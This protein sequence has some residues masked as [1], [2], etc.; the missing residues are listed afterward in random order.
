MS[1]IKVPNVGW[2]TLNVL[3]V[4]HNRYSPRKVAKVANSL[5]E[6][7][8]MPLFD[9]IEGD[10]T[11]FF[12]SQGT[13]FDA[14]VKSFMDRMAL[15]ESR[16]ELLR[17]D[18][19]NNFHSVHER[20]DRSRATVADAAV[21]AAA[22]AASSSVLPVVTV[23]DGRNEELE[24]YTMTLSRQLNMVLELL[25]QPHANDAVAV[26]HA[27][28]AQFHSISDVLTENE[29]IL[30]QLAMHPEPRFEAEQVAVPVEQIHPAV[31][32]DSSM[33]E[34]LNGSSLEPSKP[35]PDPI[36]SSLSLS[37]AQEQP[38]VVVPNAEAAPPALQ[39]AQTEAKVAAVA[40]EKQPD[41][42]T[43]APKQE[44][45]T[46]S[47]IA[48]ATAINAKEV[49][50]NEISDNQTG[51]RK[52]E[53][54]DEDDEEALDVMPVEARFQSPPAHSEDALHRT[55]SF[56]RSCQDLQKS[57][58]V[59]L[60][61][62]RLREEE[63]MRRLQQLLLQS[64]A[65]VQHEHLAAWQKQQ[66][67]LHGQHRQQQT[68][69]MQLLR[70]LEIQL[71]DQQQ[72]E[73]QHFQA[74]QV[75][76]DQ[77]QRAAD[78]ESVQREV[79]HKLEAINTL[80]A[81][82]QATH[83][84]ELAQMTQLIGDL[85]TRFVSSDTLEAAAAVWLQTAAD[86]CVYGASPATLAKLEQDMEDYQAQLS[87]QSTASPAIVL[88]GEAV[89]H[90]VQLLRVV[91]SLGNPAVKRSEQEATMYTLRQLLAKVDKL[92]QAAVAENEDVRLPG[93]EFLAEAIHRMELGTANLLDAVDFQQETFQQTSGQQQAGLEKL[94]KEL[95]RQQQVEKLLKAQLSTCP[96]QEE[97][98]RLV[99]EL[100]DQV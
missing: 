68:E 76:Q 9:A 65:H 54:L 43:E 27:K 73:E 1:R 98:L 12:V 92:S 78:L 7:A 20:I 74:W 33:R 10:V 29:A 47:P 97:T 4:P 52:D 17:A 64:R 35:I 14:L 40:N 2:P 42:P 88:L 100:R 96:S 66:D 39:T 34:L 19:T 38:K 8:A 83:S 82:A 21:E 36:S 72:R 63:L 32:P 71:Q 5:H 59:R 58:E 3:N 6:D 69:Q 89:D 45:D 91:P 62:Q 75:S 51:V 85:D 13:V 57:E 24:Y 31:E 93:T 22:A 50:A 41:R 99:Q 95:W 90:V 30:M 60:R 67:E 77:E 55:K 94:Q 44:L 25:F 84:H 87:L 53:E 15:V 46:V 16:V 86:N 18:V 81:T 56:Y 70:Q 23:V 37:E 79:S 11:A 28:Q 80:M 61:D 49:V 48:E 26:V